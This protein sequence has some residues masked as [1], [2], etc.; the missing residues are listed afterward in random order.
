MVRI[1]WRIITHHLFKEYLT[2]VEEF[3]IDVTVRNGQNMMCELKVLVNMKLQSGEKVNQDNVIYVLQ[4]VKNL[5]S[6]SRLMGKGGTITTT[7]HK[8]AINTN[9]VSVNPM[10]QLK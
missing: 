10:F 4:A 2:G 9:G 6:S 3:S 5:L 1:K 7:K 8:M